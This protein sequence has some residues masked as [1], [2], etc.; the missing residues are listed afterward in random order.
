M[1]TCLAARLIAQYSAPLHNI[2]LAL[3]FVKDLSATSRFVL[4]SAT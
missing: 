2:P 3:G 1:S 4:D